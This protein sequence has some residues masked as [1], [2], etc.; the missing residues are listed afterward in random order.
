MVRMPSMLAQMLGPSFYERWKGHWW[1]APQRVNKEFYAAGIQRLTRGRKS[2]LKILRFCGKNT[3]NYIK[4][5]F[6]AQH[7]LVGQGL[8][9]IE[10][11]LSYCSR[12]LVRWWT[13]RCVKG[14][15]SFNPLAF[16]H[17]P[18]EVTTSK[19]CEDLIFG[20]YV[21]Y[22]VQKFMVYFGEEIGDF[23]LCCG[24]FPPAEIYAG[25]FFF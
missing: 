18:P 12:T 4:D 6:M 11:S 22:W 19:L 17:V 23:R 5:F 16:P 15:L 24:R 10:A 14:F 20:N 21:W 9:I 2:A 7:P 13:I 1:L 8:L 3:C 25:V